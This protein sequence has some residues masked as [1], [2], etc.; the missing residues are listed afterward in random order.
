MKLISALL[1]LPVCITAVIARDPLSYVPDPPGLYT[2]AKPSGVTTLLDLIKSRPELSQLA[3]TIQIPAGFDKAFDTAPTWPFTYFAPSNEAFNHTGQYYE[4]YASTPKGKMWL[5]NLLNHHYIPNS[6]L[7]TSNFN[8]TLT[9]IQTGSYLYISTQSV[10]GTLTL[11]NIAKVVEGNIP[12]T[13]SANLKQGIVHV[14][15]RIL[16]PSAQV[17]ELDQ[18]Q[19]GQE[20]IAGSCLN[21]DLPYC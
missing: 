8:S 7:T 2:A 15:D 6:A 5:G 3:D 10:S 19:I 17:Y 18:P 11:N 21:L 16:D 12:V 1:F 13:R 20:F 9:R 14:I 4:T